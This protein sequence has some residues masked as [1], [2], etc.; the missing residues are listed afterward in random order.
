MSLS[1]AAEA[2]PVPGC[3]E[4]PGAA[5]LPPPQPTPA[6]GTGRCPAAAGLSPRSGCSPG[7]AGR[8]RAGLEVLGVSSST[9]ASPRFLRGGG[10]VCVC[11]CLSV[12]VC[13]CV[14]AG[15]GGSATS[16]R[17]GTPAAGLDRARSGA[18]LPRGEVTPGERLSGR[19]GAEAP[20]G[21]GG[22][23]GGGSSSSRRR[24][25][26]APGARECLRGGGAEGRG[27]AGAPRS[28][29]RHPAA[30]AAS[31]ARGVPEGVQGKS[32][33]SGIS[34][35]SSE[36]SRGLVSKLSAVCSRKL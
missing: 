30:A 23:G 16:R 6:G 3:R 33:P 28:R 36:G 7:E 18:F 13:V 32:P 4:L 17:G 12:C 26:E 29:R 34:L 2:Q 5:R 8:V 9:P 35:L 14:L 27:T 15:R 21:G 19:A 10:C 20:R 25:G 22:G 11:V 1:K 24:S 31:S